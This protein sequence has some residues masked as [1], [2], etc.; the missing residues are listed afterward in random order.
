MPLC[1]HPASVDGPT[2]RHGYMSSGLS[3]CG[4][5]QKDFVL[6]DL[7]LTNSYQIVSL[8]DILIACKQDDPICNHYGPPNN[9]T[10][11]YCAP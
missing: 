6:M 11:S 10:K 3:A 7:N 5:K 4:P 8:F 9:K 1:N 2:T